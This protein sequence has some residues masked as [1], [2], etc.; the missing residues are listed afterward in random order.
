MYSPI[1]FVFARWDVYVE[2]VSLVVN[3]CWNRIV[4]TFKIILYIFLH[5]QVDALV[6]LS[7]CISSTALYVWS[8]LTIGFLIDVSVIY[9]VSCRFDTWCISRK[10][11][12]MTCVYNSSK[13]RIFPGQSLFLWFWELCYSPQGFIL[14]RLVF[15]LVT[16]ANHNYLYGWLYGSWKLVTG[17]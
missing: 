3:S 5:L 4:N 13:G 16:L 2:I 10:I 6:C 12:W 9:V 17:L 7:G 11:S 15:I 8:F 14:F 1:L